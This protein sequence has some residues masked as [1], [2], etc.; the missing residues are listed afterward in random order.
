MADSGENSGREAEEEHD[1]TN[2]RRVDE[3]VP[4]T[5]GDPV[6]P[7]V[8]RGPRTG[9]RRRRL[10]LHVDLNNTVLVSDS[11]TG[12]GPA[13][14]LEYFLSTVTWG[15]MSAQGDVDLPDDVSDIIVK[16][17]VVNQPP[18]IISTGSK[19]IFIGITHMSVDGIY[20]YYNV[21]VNIYI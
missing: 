5:A 1:G 19:V 3:P 13:A 16:E 12:Q 17:Q 10:V 2:G 20:L 8:P 7:P 14:A 18:K 15:K 11:V 6:G 9:D 4:R 21:K